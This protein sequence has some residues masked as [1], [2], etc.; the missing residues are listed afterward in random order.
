MK[1]A[2]LTV[3]CLL[4]MVALFVMQTGSVAADGWCRSC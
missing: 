2:I 1:L 3:A 4:V